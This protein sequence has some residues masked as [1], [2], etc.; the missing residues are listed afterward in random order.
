MPL[1]MPYYSI[2]GRKQ[3]VDKKQKEI[4]KNNAD[5]CFLS[6]FLKEN[7]NK[8]NKINLGNIGSLFHEIQFNL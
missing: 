7:C 8:I 3:N 4:R 5:P 6:P 1:P 2:Q